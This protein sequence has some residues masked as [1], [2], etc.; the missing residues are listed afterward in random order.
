MDTAA[1]MQSQARTEPDIEAEIDMLIE[2]PGS[3]ARH[4]KKAIAK[5]YDALLF[6]LLLSISRGRRA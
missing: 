5:V 1:S 2:R 4:L 6:K 3:L